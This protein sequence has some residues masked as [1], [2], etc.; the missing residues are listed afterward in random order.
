MGKRQ[1]STSPR[2]LLIA[3]GVFGLL[4]AVLVVVTRY[5]EIQKARAEAVRAQREADLALNPAPTAPAIS[6]PGA[7]APVGSGN[8][9]PISDTVYYPLAPGVSMA[10]C[11]IPPGSATLGSPAGEFGR[12]PDEPEK[13]FVSKGFWLGKY[14]VTQ[15]EWEAVTRTNPSTFNGK[16]PGVVNGLNTANFP[17]DDLSWIDAQNFIKSLAAR[18]DAPSVF[19]K[20]CSFCLPHEDEWEYAC[21]GGRGNAIPFYFGNALNGRDSNCDGTRPFGVPAFGPMLGRTC[22]VGSY[23]KLAPHPWGLCDMHGNVHEYCETEARPANKRV[24]RGGC[25]ASPPVLCRSAVRDIFGP[26]TNRYNTV[27]MRVCVRPE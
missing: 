4:G 14:E 19:G 11:W 8:A 15:A 26:D 7:A 5:Y 23:E 2:W 18:R 1:E 10:F 22:A 6:N 13:Q 21:R 27:G 17:V 25:Y 3:T 9:R 20:P 24:L 16:R 12:R